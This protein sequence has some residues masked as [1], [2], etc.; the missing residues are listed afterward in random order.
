MAAEEGMTEADEKPEPTSSLGRLWRQLE[1]MSMD[2][3]PNVGD[4]G[5]LAK[6]GVLIPMTML[7]IGVFVAT[8]FF[9]T[10]NNANQIAAQNFLSLT[11]D[12]GFICNTV[13][14][15]IT[16]S[17][18]GDLNGAWSTNG[19]FQ[20]NASFYQLDFSGAAVTP[21][22]FRSN[23]EYFKSQL[24]IIGTKMQTRDSLFSLLALASFG[25]I[26]S[27]GTGLTFSVGVLPVQVF[28]NMKV[29]SNGFYNHRG[30]CVPQNESSSATNDTVI[31]V[32]TSRVDNSIVVMFNGIVQTLG[33]YKEPCPLQIPSLYHLFGYKSNTMGPLFSFKID[34]RSLVDIVAFNMGM[35]T[36]EGMDEID[37]GIDP[38]TVG[39]PDGAFYV[40][41]FYPLG[42]YAPVFCVSDDLKGGA[43]NPD[44]CFLLAPGTASSSVDYGDVLSY[45]LWYPLI[46]SYGDFLNPSISKGPCQCP[47]D[48]DLPQCNVGDYFITLFYDTGMANGGIANNDNTVKIGKHFQS[49]LLADPENGDIMQSKEVYKIAM[50][51]AAMYY[52]NNI[53]ESRFTA[54]M[55]SLCP[56][57]QCGVLSIELFQD[58]AFSP[59]TA[60]QLN[61]YAIAPNYVA[62][63][64]RKRI[65]C[66]DVIYLPD[67]IERMIKAPPVQLIQPF[68]NCHVD[69]RTAL[70]TSIGVAQ[71]YAQLTSGIVTAIIAFVVINYINRVKAAGNPEDKISKP[72]S[73]ADKEKRDMLKAIAQLQAEVATLKTGAPMPSQAMQAAQAVGK[74]SKAP[75]KTKD[76]LR[77]D[78]VKAGALQG[79]S[80]S[81]SA[82]DSD[83]DSDSIIFG[84]TELAKRG[85]N[86]VWCITDILPMAVIS[87]GT[88]L[89]PA[90]PTPPQSR[91]VTNP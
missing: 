61:L 80:D 41:P 76:K 19:D 22:A 4:P 18:Y 9:F 77:R 30:R 45:S 25:E 72:K 68:L 5:D 56:D 34:I 8:L 37:L 69:V 31:R 59:L 79:D 39:F 63:S 23:M 62:G 84:S 67:A 46:V 78:K 90:L 74:G 14:L 75:L 44:I 33:G 2:S 40:D 88:A 43:N 87:P 85:D 7:Y 20:S 48:K 70:L 54:E 1:E 10:I 50:L 71:G 91:A 58:S 26:A 42:D 13:P 38:S 47:R 55:N 89:P 53:T 86:S 81:D 3:A 36:K 64:T 32:T 57:K 6:H 73:K 52:N 60:G 21:G 82:G 11:A 51:A 24:Q 16:A 29:Y 28:A 35:T 49:F 15:Y 83:S 65:M 27:D 17:F 66:S 12:S